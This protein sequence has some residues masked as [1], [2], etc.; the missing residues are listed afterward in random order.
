M[1]PHRGGG[2]AKTL[3]ALAIRQHASLGTRLA[4]VTNCFKSLNRWANEFAAASGGA[5]RA[6]INPDRLGVDMIYV[7]GAGGFSNRSSEAVI[8]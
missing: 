2:P 7:F 1:V 5:K 3:L 4:F 6:S 8:Q